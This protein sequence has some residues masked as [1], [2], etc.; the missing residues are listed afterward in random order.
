L[1]LDAHEHDRLVALTSHLPQLASTALASAV[2]SQ[3][4]SDEELKVSGPGFQ[5]LTRLALSSWDIWSDIVRTNTALIDHALEVYIDKLTEIR[6]NLRTQ[7]IGEEFVL[8]AEVASRV[9]RLG[10]QKQD[11]ETQRGSTC[12]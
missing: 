5:D 7:R 9:R 4:L 11:R 10:G 2:H 3:L 6:K 1:I 8:A 12:E